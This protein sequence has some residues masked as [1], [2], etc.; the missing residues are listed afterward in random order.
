MW[1]QAPLPLR[2]LSE[3]LVSRSSGLVGAAGCLTGHELSGL[4]LAFTPCSL[5]QIVEAVATFRVLFDGDGVDAPIGQ[6]E[7]AR[8]DSCSTK[9]ARTP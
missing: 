3:R 2:Q 6:C 9:G 4:L 5:V 8:G 7:G 1:S